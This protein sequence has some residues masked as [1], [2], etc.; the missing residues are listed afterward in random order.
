MVNGS[1]RLF[2]T[3][4]PPIDDGG[5]SNQIRPGTNGR[6]RCSS[7]HRYLSPTD[8]GGIGISKGDQLRKMVHVLTKSKRRICAYTQGRKDPQVDDT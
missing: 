1:S 4:Q 2:R 8:V 6:R 5:R 3:E 7:F